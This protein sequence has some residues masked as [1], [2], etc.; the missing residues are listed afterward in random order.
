M[1]ATDFALDVDAHTCDLAYWIVDNL[2]D[3]EVYEDDDI[4]VR[5]PKAAAQVRMKRVDKN[6][7]WEVHLRALV[8]DN[9]GP[10]SKLIRARVGNRDERK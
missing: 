8:K 4:W 3:G 6:Q 1:S 7:G 9:G 5:R 2:G 10:S